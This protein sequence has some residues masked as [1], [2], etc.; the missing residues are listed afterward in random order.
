V[1]YLRGKKTAISDTFS[2]FIVCLDSHILFFLEKVLKYQHLLEWQGHIALPSFSNSHMK[3]SHKPVCPIRVWGTS[4]SNEWAFSDHYTMLPDAPVAE[5]LCKLVLKLWASWQLEYFLVTSWAPG[6]WLSYK[7]QIAVLIP[8]SIPTKWPWWR[9]KHLKPK[10]LPHFDLLAEK[11]AHAI[12]G[13]RLAWPEGIK[14]Q[15]SIISYV[16]RNRGPPTLKSSI[17]SSN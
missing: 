5:A 11:T 4:H 8:D 1:Q 12:N 15:E 17:I 6:H 9:G 14:I 16:R 3:A 7:T 10:D 2:L 13:S